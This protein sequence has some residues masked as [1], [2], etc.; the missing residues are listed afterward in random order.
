M[1]Q[2]TP[3]CPHCGRPPLFVL[4]EG[5]QAFCGRLSC[6]VLTWDSTQSKEELEANRTVI[7]AT[8]WERS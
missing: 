2:P 8:A 4:D 5:R 7:D 3:L 6:D 1:T